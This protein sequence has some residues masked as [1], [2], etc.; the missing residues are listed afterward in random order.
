MAR[1]TWVNEFEKT[2]KQ[3]KYA[4]EAR[5]RILEEM[6]KEARI[7]KIEELKIRI[8][9]AR[10]KIGPEDWMAMHKIR[11]MEMELEYFERV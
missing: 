5:I 1:N 6:G 11:P 4:E 10:N 7:N 3:A 2:Q 8:E 9:E